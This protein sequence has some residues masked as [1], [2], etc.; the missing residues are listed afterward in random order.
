MVK[1]RTNVKKHWS[2]LSDAVGAYIIR[3][4][5]TDRNGKLHTGKNYKIYLR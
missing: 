5:F 1:S 2:Y 4:S 3:R